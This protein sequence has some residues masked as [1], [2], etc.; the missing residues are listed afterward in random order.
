MPM[1]SSG[2]DGIFGTVDLRSVSQKLWEL[3]VGLAPWLLPIAGLCVLGVRGRLGY[4]PI[5]ISSTGYWHNADLNNL[6]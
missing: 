2:G 3:R 4:N 6:G 1:V 5:K